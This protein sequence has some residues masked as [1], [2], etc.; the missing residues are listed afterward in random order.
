MSEVNDSHLEKTL[1]K[2]KLLSI[3]VE[4]VN[5]PL[6]KHQ[7]HRIDNLR[8]QTLVCAACQKKT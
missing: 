8:S 6:R 5:R 4:T 2:G 7:N 1:G 3:E